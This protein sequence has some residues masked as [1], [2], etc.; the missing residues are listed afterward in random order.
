MEKSKYITALNM[1]LYIIIIILSIIKLVINF[2]ETEYSVCIIFDIIFNFIILISTI[3]LIIVYKFYEIRMIIGSII[4]II[5]IGYILTSVFSY[6]YFLNDSK[7]RGIYN[8]VSY[9]KISLVALAHFISI[10]NG[11]DC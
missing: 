2:I 6:S 5:W 7:M 9:T 8:F 1:S 10:S 3:I 11:D 4:M